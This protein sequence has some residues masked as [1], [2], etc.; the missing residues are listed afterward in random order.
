MSRAPWVL[1]LTLLDCD[2][3]LPK[4]GPLTLR[5]QLT[6]EGQINFYQM[7]TGCPSQV[8]QKIFYGGVGVK[9]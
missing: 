3:V 8:V 6:L 2:K 4:R 9:K 1:P 7:V 5:G